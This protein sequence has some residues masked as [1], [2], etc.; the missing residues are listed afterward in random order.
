[1]NFPDIVRADGTLVLK[2]VSRS[3][4]EDDEFKLVPVETGCSEVTAGAA[5]AC[6]LCCCDNGI[7]R[8]AMIR[9]AED[10]DTTGGGRVWEEAPD[11]LSATLSASDSNV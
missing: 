8:G 6:C 9:G 5:L 10:L 11:K 7:A 2:D 4:G 1:M 3:N